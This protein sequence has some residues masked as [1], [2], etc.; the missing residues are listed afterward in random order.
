MLLIIV[1]LISLIGFNLKE[2]LPSVLGALTLYIIFRQMHLKLVEEEEWRPW[3]SATLILVIAVVVIVIPTYFLID[4]LLTKVGDVQQYVGKF[5]VFLEKIQGYIQSKTGINIITVQN[6]EKV[7]EYITK[8]SSAAVNATL[9]IIAILAATFFILYFMLVNSRLF[10]KVTKSLTPLKKANVEKIGSKVRRMIVANAVGIPVVA[11]GQGVV[12][13]IGYFIFGAPSPWLLF[14][15]TCV[16]SM[17]PVVGSALV[18][19]PVGIFM[20][21]NGDNTGGIGVILYGMLVV[22]TIDNIFRFTFLKKLEDIHPLNTV[23]GII[24]GLKLFGFMGLIFG[25]ILVSVSILLM[26]VYYDE[27]TYDE[28]EIILPESEKPLEKKIDLTL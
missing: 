21:A 1:A 15:L 5:N 10:E 12:A 25:P 11:I 20:L 23:F 22:G 28:N 19:A 17:I 16:A 14:V 3:V 13:L 26:Q 2:F 4:M 8:Y 24:L 7:A 18:Y 27:F 6:K 9:N